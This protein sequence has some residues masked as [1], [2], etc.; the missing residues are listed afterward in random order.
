M[1]HK[2]PL[3]SIP[4]DEL[5][6]R[7]TELM[8]Q[9]RRVESDLVAH[10]GEVEERRLFAREASSSMFAYCT[11]VLH[12][13]EAEAYL[14]IAVARASREHPV[15]LTMLGDGR[16]HLTGIVRLAP[17]LTRQ[18]RDALLERATHRS[19]RQIEELVAE[20]APRPDVRAV[21]RKLPERQA[22]PK[23]ALPL[24]P[25]GMTQAARELRPERVPAPI[26][27]PAPPAAV[28]QPLAPS[29]YKVQF[30]ASA[31]LRDKLERLQ[32]LMRSQVPDGDLAAI[33]EQAVTE[34][35][36]RLEAKRFA[37]TTVPRKGLS[38]TDTSPSSR[39]IPAAVRRAVHERDGDRCRYVD[40]QGRRCSERERLE[41]HH[42]HPFGMGGDHRPENVR[43]M[44][45]THNRYAAEHDY[46]KSAMARYRRS[47][48]PCAAVRPPME[49]GHPERPTSART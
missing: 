27:S 11:E 12:L 13:S 44:C 8:Q 25:D 21:I 14:R 2:R 9:S 33:I 15:L 6:R 47:R 24:G 37:R 31:G 16:L 43:L 10:I 41:Y 23:P 3:E 38:G 19:K 42:L 29:R 32:A 46:G 4:D 5:L 40:R 17:H 35:L 45:R 18:N 48:D 34:K 39:H 22:L 28:V 26:P 20:I 7:L 49:K 36:G 30:T 1:E